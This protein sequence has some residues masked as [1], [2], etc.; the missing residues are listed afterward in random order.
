MA[1][2]IEKYQIDVENDQLFKK[3]IDLFETQPNYQVW[4]VKC[5][6]SKS[7]GYDFLVSLKEWADKNPQYIK[8]L[9][10]QNIVSYSKVTD[11]NLLKR[12]MRGIDM[13]TALNR[14]FSKFNT[15]QR[16]LLKTAVFTEEMT[17]LAASRNSFIKTLY[18]KFTKFERLPDNKKNNIYVLASSFEKLEEILTLIDESLVESYEWNKEDMLAFME[19][20][21]KCEV[22]KDDGDIVVIKVPDYK[23]SAAMCGG[24]RTQWCITKKEHF[25]KDY[26]SDYTDPK[27]EQFF[28]FDFSKP[29]T[30]QFAHVGFTTEAGKGIIY[31]HS[32]RNKDIRNDTISVNGVSYNIEKVLEEDHVTMDELI[33]IIKNS[34]FDWNASSL[35]SFLENNSE[36]YTIKY[37][38]E[39]VVI[40]EIS[41]AQ[42]EAFIDLLGNTQ[43]S[44][45]GYLLSDNS[46]KLYAIFNFNVNYDKESSVYLAT[47]M[48]DEYGISSIVQLKSPRNVTLPNEALG[49]IGVHPSDFITREDVD[50]RIMLHKYIDERDEESA[51]KLIQEC[52]DGFD[53]NYSFRNRMPI[54]SAMYSKQYRVF[55]AIMHHPKYKIGK[56]DGWGETLL[57][58]LIYYYANLNI[59]DG[60]LDK[61]G[62]ERMIMSILSTDDKSLN[63]SDLN[64]DTALIIACEYGINWIIQELI[65]SKRVDVNKSNDSNMTALRVLIT[66]KNQS[67][68][69]ILTK[70]SDLIISQEDIELAKNNN[71]DLAGMLSTSDSASY[72]YSV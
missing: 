21:T 22:V 42:K 23:S 65:K 15:E 36:R 47:C 53:V 4:A 18:E 56:K 17:P 61:E 25:F 62:I 51:I 46:V 12:E 50:P 52:G 32:C 9:S 41:N 48:K 20:N 30:H 63:D 43:L 26:V 28:L 3:V 31:A 70:R 34:N 37:I 19:N 7:I 39:N 64:N 69:E 54:F 72:S 5:A 66:N 1:P 38:K 58:T 24:G 68:I 16:E 27:R 10:K 29:E 33:K 2:L 14:S 35:I 6:F 57:Q 45:G 67:G 49:N 8:M 59:V 13:L 44:S 11:I 60:S 71:V 55:D 40:V